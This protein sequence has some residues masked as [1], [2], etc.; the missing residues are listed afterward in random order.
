MNDGLYIRLYK[1]LYGTFTLD[2][3]KHSCVALCLLNLSIK[4][5][6][7]PSYGLIIDGTLT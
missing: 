5:K 6:F 7:H 3:I 4:I 1:T 2:N